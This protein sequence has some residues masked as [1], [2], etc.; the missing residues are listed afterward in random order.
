LNPSLKAKVIIPGNL[1]QPLWYEVN[2]LDSGSVKPGILVKVPLRSRTV[3][4]LVMELKKIELPF[5]SKH[6]IEVVPWKQPFS[7]QWLN[8]LDWMGD[9]YH[10]PLSKVLNTALPRYALKLIEEKSG[11]AGEVNGP[12]RENADLAA[13]TYEL[14]GELRKVVRQ[15]SRL[16]SQKGE[17]AS[18]TFLLK[19]AAGSG[20]TAVFIE[21]VRE[22]LNIG[23]NVLILVPEIALTPFSAARF[24]G[25]QSPGYYW[26]KICCSLPGTQSRI[27]HCG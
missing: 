16:F 8:L 10:T 19:G 25:E 21:L 18:Q 7:K 11:K 27:S 22:C 26:G 6:I 17:G 12:K 20:K 4:G 5:E 14:S 23:K 2:N 3:T 13:D 1:P 24:S 9:Y 15:I